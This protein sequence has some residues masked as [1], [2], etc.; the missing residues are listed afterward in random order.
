[1]NFANCNLCHP[2]LVVSPS[3]GDAMMRH[4]LSPGGSDRLRQYQVDSL[5]EV[6]VDWGQV[7]FAA[8]LSGRHDG[9]VDLLKIELMVHG[10][11]RK[12][13]M[14]LV[15]RQDE[16]IEIQTLNEL[17]EMAVKWK[18][19]PKDGV[20]YPEYVCALKIWRG[21]EIIAKRVLHAAPPP[22]DEDL[23]FKL[24]ELVWAPGL[25]DDDPQLLAK[26]QSNV[27]TKN[28]TLEQ[29]RRRG[30]G[31]E[32]ETVQLPPDFEDGCF[33]HQQQFQSLVEK[34]RIWHQ[35][36]STDQDSALWDG[37]S[38]WSVSHDLYVE[39]GAPPTRIRLSE[40][41]NALAHSMSEDSMR[42]LNNL[43]LGG[44]VEIPEELM[45]R[46][47]PTVNGDDIPASQASPEYKSPAPPHELYHA[48]P[49]PEDGNDE[50]CASIRLFFD[51]VIKN[52]AVSSRPLLVPT[53]IVANANL[54]GSRRKHFSCGL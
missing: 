33:T 18:H 3:H 14:V 48:F 20:L 41:I 34:A 22:L 27:T 36:S 42:T 7:D 39:N 30:F 6:S 12:P 13:A 32:L 17:P 49:P 2:K 43:I 21:A 24:D 37:L 28:Q 52:G 25:F 35:Q 10:I 23:G 53:G 38:K 50:A 47:S 1:M 5:M 54:L 8:I 44:R 26:I 31:I 29:C 4:G 46:I 45:D 16:R 40:R 11:C 19:E 51:G 9:Q 15:V